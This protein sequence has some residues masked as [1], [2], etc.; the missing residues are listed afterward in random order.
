M[1]YMLMPMP[2]A[3]KIVSSRRMWYLDEKECSAKAEVRV[4]SFFISA[5][6]S[7]ILI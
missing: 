3:K 5:P 1:L 2:L 6:C 4:R 7:L